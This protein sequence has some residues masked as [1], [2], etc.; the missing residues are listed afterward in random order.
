MTLNS[1]LCAPLCS[2][3]L[4]GGSLSFFIDIVPLRIVMRGMMLYKYF[5]LLFVPFS[6]AAQSELESQSML[7]Q[8]DL[9][10]K[11]YAM[12]VAKAPPPSPLPQTQ[13]TL[14]TSSIWFTFDLTEV[15]A[16][17]GET[18]F[19][20]LNRQDLWTQ[21][22]ELG[23]DGIR[24]ENLKK[25]GTLRT[26]LG[27]DPCWGTDQQWQQLAAG[28]QG[29]GFT[30]IGDSI[31]SSIGLT[32]DFWLALQNI[33]DYPGLYHLIEIEKR[34]WKLLPTISQGQFSENV[35]WLSLQE[36]R[37]K[38]Y[39]P[40]QYQPYIKE[41]AWNATERITGTDGKMRRWIY[42]KENRFDPVLDWLDPSYAGFRLA[43]ADSI[44]S[45]YKL[46]Q[47][48]FVFD[49]NLP[50][51]ARENLPLWTRKIGAFSAQEMKGGIEALKNIHSDLAF[52]ILTPSALLHAL[53]AEDAGALRLTYR[54]MLEEGIQP[55]KLIHVM[56]PFDKFA[57][58]WSIF[59]ENP[60]KKYH[61]Y[62]EYITGEALRKRLLKEDALRLGNTRDNSI[63]TSTWPGY[64]AF[65]LGVADSLPK[66]DA[67]TVAQDYEK[68]RAQIQEA[69]LLLA[70]FYAMQPGVFSF[71]VYDLLGA[72][73]NQT[74]CLDLMGC[75]QSTL[76]A[77]LPTQMMNS[78]SFASQLKTMLQLR[79][80]YKI[81]SAELMNVPET[82]HKN[83]LIL[84]HKLKDTGSTYIL[85]VNF[86]KKNVEELIELPSLKR[87]SAINLMTGL[88]E[89][90][91]LE[92]SSFY[93]KLP[94]MSGKALFFQPK[95]YD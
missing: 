21:L 73:P 10:A 1:L 84:I 46:G 83:S 55:E 23:V 20:A 50:P 54:L 37:K 4:C 88:T 31:S 80:N 2:L 94:A 57:C 56:Q 52:D 61:Y 30:L 72:L 90:K 64:C 48:I 95:Y 39:V 65:T 8:A 27:L 17:S 60:Q 9:I 12:E 40:E 93:L 76:Y 33:R 44:E 47:K 35:P 13:K 63:P 5:P 3:C 34:D 70:F 79:K 92:S 62:E 51:Y 28:L 32:A 15:P 74:E 87:T 22:R 36:L 75:N 25:G 77:C 85:A 58:D 49:A 41:S 38:G 59:L 71:S 67:A 91:H 89:E 7:Y 42:L 78:S 14:D 69:H 24:F 68:H 81:E 6:L 11:K 66:N 18:I 53:I 86:G 43:A 19:Q 29:K 45:V 26:G 16:P 82:P